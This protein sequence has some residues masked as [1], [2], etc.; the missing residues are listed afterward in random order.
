MIITQSMGD[1][2][3]RHLA[4]H[5]YQ[6]NFMPVLPAL[7]REVNLYKGKA[8]AEAAK[9]PLVIFALDNEFLC[10][11]HFKDRSY[12]A[13]GTIGV[14]GVPSLARSYLTGQ[15]VNLWFEERVT[16]RNATRMY[17]IEADLE[18]N[19]QVVSPLTNDNVPPQVEPVTSNTLAW[20]LVIGTTFALAK[21]IIFSEPSEKTA[22]ERPDATPGSGPAH[23]AGA[24]GDV[25]TT[26][27]TT[28]GV[29]GPDG[30]IT[31]PSSL[32]E[33]ATESD[34]AV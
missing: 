24:R 21:A 20:S 25:E 16:L 23:G 18:V 28:G 14:N 10:V 7:V 8:A 3:V 6:D 17:I 1:V 2:L 31:P 33:D 30:S 13:V 32:E 15:D 34:G 22:E 26:H 29:A 19:K 4:R 11:T 9:K 5:A 27:V 12:S